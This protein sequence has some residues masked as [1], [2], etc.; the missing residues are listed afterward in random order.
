MTLE[1]KSPQKRT[2][3][4]VT[5][6]RGGCLTCKSR[7]LRCPEN[8]PICSRCY[9]DNRTC[10]YGIQLQW[11]DDAR[12]RGIKHGRTTRTDR[13]GL[14]ASKSSVWLSFPR[15]QGGRY[16][17]NTFTSDLEGNIAVPMVEGLN[18][19]NGPLWHDQHR[20]ALHAS[21]SMVPTLFFARDTDSRID[22]VL[23]NYYNKSVS[24]VIPLLDSSTNLFRHLVLPLA[25]SNEAVMHMVLAIGALSLTARGQRHLYLTALRHKQRS[26]QLLREYI[27][28][29]AVSAANDA[30]VIVVLM[31]CVFEMSDNC[32]ISWSAHLSAALDL[33]RLASTHSSTGGITPQVVEFVSRFFLVKDALGRTA[34]GKVAKINELPPVDSSEIDPSIGCSYELIDIISKIT[35]LARDLRNPQTN[36]RN[37]LAK[38]SE[39]ET[40]LSSL[41]QHLPPT[42][43]HSIPPHPSPSPPSSITEVTILQHTSRLIH[44]STTLYLQATLRSLSPYSP[45]AQS[46]ITQIIAHTKPLSPIHLRSAHLWPLFVGAVFS[47]GDDAERVWFL[48]QFDA[49]ENDERALVARGSVGRVRGIV[50]RVWKRR[51]LEGERDH[52][53]GYCNRNNVAENVDV[54]VK[55]D[56]ERYVQPLSDGLCLG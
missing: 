44:T 17:L 36:Q 32:Q 43:S 30:N 40:Q 48:N 25:L 20:H 41:T 34:C 29:N 26:M 2:G 15:D 28:S 12:K 27:A 24:N 47:T 54:G 37:W 31:L 6:S 1:G 50:E 11:E 18:F 45:T 51:D 23:F 35:D 53:G 14:S 38:S 9:N 39:L 19:D 52:T 13:A 55:G 22:P 8:K 10:S 33:M 16:F 4:R 49:L 42:T 5:H 3:R 56:W 46:L 21:P 7:K